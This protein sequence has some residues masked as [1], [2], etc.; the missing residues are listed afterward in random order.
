MSHLEQD[1][2]EGD[3]N[4]IFEIKSI[5]TRNADWRIKI[6]ALHSLAKLLLQDLSLKEFQMMFSSVKDEIV[7]QL[8]ERRSGKVYYCCIIMKTNNPFL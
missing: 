3:E 1:L 2:S 7:L 6:Q 5:L 4:D 8:K